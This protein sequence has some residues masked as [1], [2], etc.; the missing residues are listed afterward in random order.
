MLLVIEYL[1][2]A[3]ISVICAYLSFFFDSSLYQMHQGF[4]WLFMAG[5]GGSLTYLLWR[6]V[7]DVHP[8]L[9]PKRQGS[10]DNSSVRTSIQKSKDGPFKRDQDEIHESHEEERENTLESWDMLNLKGMKDRSD[11]GLDFIESEKKSSSGAHLRHPSKRYEESP[12][13]EF[14]E[15]PP[16]SIIQSDLQS[17]DAL[18]AKMGSTSKKTL[19]VAN[20]RNLKAGSDLIR[21]LNKYETEKSSLT[22]F[23][24]YPRI[25]LIPHFGKIKNGFSLEAFKS[26]LIS[27]LFDYDK[28]VFFLSQEDQN[29]LRK[30]LAQQARVETENDSDQSP[31]LNSF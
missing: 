11:L 4:Y 27:I 20:F 8:P 12:S 19:I 18:V 17:L 10:T 29:H 24:I 16:L 1:T 26:F 23:E 6:I 2:L 5:C 22:C 14:V 9:A 28:I 13:L 3:I 15:K 21:N 25:N 7:S 30:F 31:V